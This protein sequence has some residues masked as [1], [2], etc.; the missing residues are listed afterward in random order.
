MK[1]IFFLLLLITVGCEKDPEPPGATAAVQTS[2]FATSIT[3]FSAVCSGNVSA[4]Y[5][6]L[7]TERGICW[8]TAANPSI[9]T[10]RIMAGTGNGAFTCTITGLLQFRKY[11]FRAYAINQ[12]GIS[13]GEISSFTTL[14]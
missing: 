7:V 12:S 1:A 11:Y 6:S 10:S 14:N 4:N 8:S 2:I 9:S 5:G 13:Y 3:R